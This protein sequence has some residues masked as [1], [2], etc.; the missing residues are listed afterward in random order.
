MS[1]S[2]TSAKKVKPDNRKQSLLASELDGF[3]EDEALE[4]LDNY[5]NENLHMLQEIEQLKLK[6]TSIS[7]DLHQEQ[8]HNKSLES[9]VLASDK[10]V[11]SLHDTKKI[12]TKQI[13]DLNSEARVST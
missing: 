3:N 6:I 13:E 8:A 5:H 11:A 1:I 12:L 9:K 7:R 2:K 10:Q 4:M